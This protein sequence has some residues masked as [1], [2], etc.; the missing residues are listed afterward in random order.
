MTVAFG[1]LGALLNG[2]S[3]T[4]MVPLF[5]G[6]LGE[7]VHLQGAP[8]FLRQLLSLFDEFPTEHRQAILF[9]AVIFCVG[10]KNVTGFASAYAVGRLRR[11][12]T[13]DLRDEA[14]RIAVEVDID[15]YTRVKLGDFITRI[16][17][18]TLRGAS[19]VLVLL[20]MV[21][22]GSAVAVFLALMVALSWKLTLVA[23][24]LVGAVAAANQLLIRRARALGTALSQRSGDYSHV[25]LEALTGIRLVKAAAAEQAEARRINEYSR[26]REEIEL[27]NFLANTAVGPVSEVSALLALSLTMV[28]GRILFAQQL[29]GLSAVLLTYLL[30]LFRALP[31]VA[32]LND[33]RSQYA[34]LSGA[35]A[36]LPE[37]LSRAEKPFMRNGSRPRVRLQRDIRFNHVQFSYP[38]RAVPVL[39][40]VDLAIPSGSMVALVGASGTG[41]TTMAL[42]V[43]RFY[44]PTSGSISL[45]GT[46][47]REFELHGLRRSIGM[48]SQDTFLFNSSV[49]HNIAYGRAEAT[50]A[51]ILDA[52][53]R[54]SAFD[55]IDKLPH[56]LDTRIGDRGVLLSGGQRQRIAIA[57]A[58]LQDA[59]I[60]ILDEATSALDSVSERVVQEAIDHARRGRTTLVIAH[61][62]STLDGVDHIAV[63]EEGRIVEMGAHDEL[64]RLGGYYARLRRLQSVGPEERTVDV[65]PAR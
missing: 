47:L 45:D 8:H 54:A 49:R 30:L 56:G 63:L 62:L 33:E 65:S 34:S 3:I 20:R 28:L 12:I 27:R 16:N 43:A 36:R 58:L 35:A 4:L 55:F 38:G 1:L 37:L 39:R 29:G 13:C 19:A 32:Q 14:I 60:L 10:L 31:L 23:L 9:A 26:A 25:L 5:M 18:E 53:R 42:L 24:L 41:K 6:F 50:D 52:A 40:D 59:D 11:D 61:R 44:D 46:D 22:T 7:E 15:F 21:A 57:R 17:W 2:V 64:M 51:E 48:V